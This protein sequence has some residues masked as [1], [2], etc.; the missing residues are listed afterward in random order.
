MASGS[1][2]FTL[3][4]ATP[5]VAVFGIDPYGDLT[6]LATSS[7]IGVASFSGVAFSE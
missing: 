5:Y 1:L 3:L 4:A 2:S 6:P 7:S